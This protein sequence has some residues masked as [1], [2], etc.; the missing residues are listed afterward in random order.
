MPPDSNTKRFKAGLNEIKARFKEFDKLQQK[1]WKTRNKQMR[2]EKKYQRDEMKS[3]E[4][5]QKVRERALKNEIRIKER[6]REKERRQF[7][8]IAREKQRIVAQKANFERRERAKRRRED[9]KYGPSGPSG[10]SGPYGGGGGSGGG[11]DS[12]RSFGQRAGGMVKGAAYTAA[13]GLIGLMLGMYIRGYK[14]YITANK[15]MSPMIGSGG[16]YGHASRGSRKGNLG[17]NIAERAQ[18]IPAM[19]RSTGQASPGAMMEAM[20]ATGMGSGEVGGIFSALAQG[21]AKFDGKGDN[22]G[23]R[24]FKEII[25]AGL[26]SGLE[27]GRLPEFFQGVTSLMQQQQSMMTGDVGQGNFSKFLGMLGR[28]GLA[29]FKGSRRRG[30]Q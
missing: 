10:P 6:A 12:R 5:A 8:Q 29:G 27:R 26:A 7:K 24:E 23:K 18:L 3:I 17:F 22:K 2:V 4:R 19:A 11:G 25:A 20:R 28:T 15:A 14:N 13:G 16:T 21:G 9:R 1:Q 30:R